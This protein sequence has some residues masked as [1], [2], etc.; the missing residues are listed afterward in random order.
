MDKEPQGA[1]TKE[2]RKRWAFSHQTIE[3]KETGNDRKRQGKAQH[4]P[5]LVA[6]SVGPQAS[7]NNAT[8]HQHSDKPP[9]IHLLCFDK[10]VGR[11]SQHH[12]QIQDRIGN[13]NRSH[14]TSFLF[15]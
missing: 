9:R 1:Q 6:K 13:Y 2:N 10:T 5:G 11:R 14:D 8:S 7:S 3:Q 15:E 12:S 4:L